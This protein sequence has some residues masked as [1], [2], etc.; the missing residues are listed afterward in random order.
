MLC[1]RARI[2]GVFSEVL[3]LTQKG[4]KE[5]KVEAATK[6][7]STRNMQTTKEEVDGTCLIS[8]GKGWSF[9]LISSGQGWIPFL[10]D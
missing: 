7:I 5:S 4:K 1:F 9:D 6:H 10:E 2:T 8:S 3:L